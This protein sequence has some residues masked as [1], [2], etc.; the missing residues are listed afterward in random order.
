MSAHLIG[1]LLSHVVAGVTA[2]Y[3]H[4]TD[5]ALADAA[6]RVAEEV[7]RRLN[8]A[9]QRDPKVIPSESPPPDVAN[10][11]CYFPASSMILRRMRSS[12][13]GE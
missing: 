10:A 1:G 5:P 2:V 13:R 8:L 11:A 7:A 9:L 3:A 4:R 12:S 6:N